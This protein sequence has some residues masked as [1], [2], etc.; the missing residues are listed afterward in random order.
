MNKLLSPLFFF[1]FIASTAIGQGFDIRSFDVR[2]EVS[3][4]GTYRIQETIKTF[5]HEEKR[6]IFR[7]IPMRY[8]VDGKEYRVVPYDIE[9][10]D[11]P[12]KIS[13]RKGY[14]RIRI[15]DPDVY[16]EGDVT[17]VIRY[18]VDG[19]YL[20]YEDRT[21]L[22]WD[23]T[24]TENLANIEYVS[25]TIELPDETQLSKEDMK[26][27][28]GYPGS[29]N[30]EGGLVQFNDRIGG[31]LNKT[32]VPG[33]GVSLA[34]KLP[35]GYFSGSSA[36]EKRESGNGG[37]DID[38]SFPTDYTA[39]LPI[40]IILGI[41]MWFRRKGRRPDAYKN[42][43]ERHYPPEG[44]NAAEVGAF[45]DF[46]VHNSDIVSMI[47]DWGRRGLIE[48][49]V[50]PSDGSD[51]EVYFY[52]TGELTGEEP[53]YERDFF[54]GLFADGDQ[55]M[56]KDLKNKF[57]KTMSE[58]SAS[59]KKWVRDYPLYDGEAESV[60]KSNNLII[61]SIL[62]MCMGVL[63]IVMW[64]LIVSGVGLIVAGVVLLVIR[65][66]RLKLSDEGVRLR[67]ELL[68]LKEFLKNP[69]SD[70]IYQLQKDDPEYL[71]KMFPYVVAFGLDKEWKKMMKSRDDSY[72]APAWYYYGNDG[73]DSAQSYGQFTDS[74]SPKEITSVFSSSPASSSSGGSSGGGSVGGG[75]G[76]GGGGSW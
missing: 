20:N 52:K 56:L 60:F 3:E 57:Y 30:E 59:L 43:E 55:V 41:I 71:D 68:G 46:T 49:R 13:N 37:V 4:D 17:Y 6:G 11:Q 34:L 23:L 66:M 10:V 32:I 40:A 31:E 28:N 69:N 22:L 75:F 74:F 29:D 27:Y 50:I 58:T 76:G 63:M 2:M 64:K 73:H 7:E 8:K 18:K 62:L 61:G 21:E 19:A 39:P 45:Y 36:Y 24:G 53:G 70:D 25:F 65:F 54:N 42:I 47:P 51:K 44:M 35:A 33:Q 15:G 48:M 16:L 12:S 38:R 26:L 67:R 1:F 72:A 5:F 14:K 9:V